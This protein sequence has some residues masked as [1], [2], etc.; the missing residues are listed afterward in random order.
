MVP[1]YWHEIRQFAGAFSGDKRICWGTWL[2]FCDFKFID[3]HTCSNLNSNRLH[4][5]R[6]VLLNAQA[7]SHLVLW[8]HTGQLCL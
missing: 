1:Q 8:Q 3:A 5:C 6:F 2:N 7:Q 4:L